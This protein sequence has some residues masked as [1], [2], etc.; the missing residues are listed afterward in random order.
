[1]KFY[2]YKYVDN[3]GRHEVHTHDCNFLPNAENRVYLGDFN[4]CNEAINYAKTQYPKH[5]F[6]GCYHCCRTCHKG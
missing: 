4:N 3:N 2:A 6:D 1:M 5:N